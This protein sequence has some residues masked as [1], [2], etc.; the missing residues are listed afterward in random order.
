M[1]MDLREL[2]AC[3]VESPGPFAHMPKIV[4]VRDDRFSSIRSFVDSEYVLQYCLTG[5]V[6]F[7]VENATYSLTAGTALI[8]PPNTPHGYR[9]IRSQ[10][11]RYIIVH[12]LL[13]P[14]STLLTLRTRHA[15]FA[16]GLRERVESCLMSL[17]DEWSGREVWHELVAPGLLLE[18]LGLTARYASESTPSLEA[19]AP[20][21]R[22]V[23]TVIH[24]LHQHYWDDISIDRMSEVAGLSPAH[25]CKSFKAYTGISPHQYLIQ[26]RIE[27]ARE[28][29]CDANM[30]CSAIAERVGF[31]TSAAF[32]RTFQKVIGKS[33]T[34]WI[35]QYPTS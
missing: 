34:H 8:M 18:V 7:R 20:S 12:F 3:S 26:I 33:P 28:L 6:D 31:P 23:D 5:D 35:K 14:N 30:T 9:V 11:Q 4:M 17:R 15:S 10:E 19:Q 1:Q 13:P 16:V 32:S 22:N 29:L 25:F 21:W 24:W 2:K 27:K